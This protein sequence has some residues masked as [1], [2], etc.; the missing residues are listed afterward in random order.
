[1]VQLCLQ[2]DVIAALLVCPGADR[3]RIL[4]IDCCLGK[5]GKCHHFVAGTLNGQGL[6]QW[7]QESSRYR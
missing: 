5:F 1:M 4:W 2:H 6:A 3:L 7:D